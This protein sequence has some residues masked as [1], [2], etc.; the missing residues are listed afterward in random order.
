M[1]PGRL[2]LDLGTAPHYDERVK[3]VGFYTAGRKPT[4]QAFF[5][6]YVRPFYPCE[7][8]TIKPHP[9]QVF[10]MFIIISV[11]N[12]DPDRKKN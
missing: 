6:S 8:L 4:R 1:I 2:K 10:I 7:I 5:L 3:K 9:L 11:S 12:N